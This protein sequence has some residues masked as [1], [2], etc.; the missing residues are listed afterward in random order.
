M[1][2]VDGIN[3]CV[4]CYAALAEQGAERTR[5][6]DRATPLWRARLAAAALLALVT[7]MTWGLFEVALPGGG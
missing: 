7:L 2:K 4:G 5:E 1:T 6:G 3:H